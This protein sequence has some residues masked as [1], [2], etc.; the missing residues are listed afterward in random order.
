VAKNKLRGYKNERE[1]EID[2][3]SLSPFP[4]LALALG[5]LGPGKKKYRYYATNYFPD[6]AGVHNTI[7]NWSEQV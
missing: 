4:L 1:K 6:F 7:G 2:K 5:A 3:P